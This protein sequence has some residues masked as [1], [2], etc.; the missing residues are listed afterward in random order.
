MRRVIMKCVICGIQIDSVD[1]AIDNGWIP[2]VWEGDHEQE[3]PFCASCSE[4]LMQLDENG[5]FELKQEYR[6]KINYKEGDF[7][8]EETQ[9][10]KS[11]GIILGY[12]DN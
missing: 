4:A 11:I 1:E 3:G 6:G 9:E 8:G 7:F 5:E 10:H 2:S 12:C